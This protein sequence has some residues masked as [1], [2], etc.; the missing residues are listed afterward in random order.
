[1]APSK[2]I[3]TGGSG[4][5]GGSVI[6]GLINPQSGTPIPAGD[7]IAV[8]R[9]EEHAAKM[10]KLGVQAPI[11]ALD[12][13]PAIEKLVLDN[14]V[15]I[16]VHCANAQEISLAQTLLEALAK[17]KEK[18]G[19]EVHYVHTSGTSAYTDRTGWI[20][21]PVR[22]TDPLY[23]LEKQIVGQ[24]P[25]RDANVSVYE[26]AKQLGV[27][28]N[29]VVP[30]F[31]YGEGLGQIGRQTIVMPLLLRSFTKHRA[32]KVASDSTDLPG[33]H[34]NDLVDFYARLIQGI[35]A[36][37][38]LTGYWTPEAHTIVLPDLT[39]GFAK[40]LHARGLVDSPEVSTWES[41]EAAGEA[42]GLPVGFVSI[43]FRSKATII[44]IRAQKE[45]GWEPKWNSSEKH[46]ASLDEEVD[47]FLRNSS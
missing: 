1:M 44:S 37:K 47:S 21:G 46:L 11:V 24:Y 7:I 36:G 20:H 17:Q 27:T 40:V 45:L 6:A 19:Q 13:G 22:D 42:F 41:D 28:L 35:R 23:E 29:T 33:I 5:I 12:D 30:P 8:V 2:I 10:S 26:L 31:I 39:A 15:G 32:V 18:T 25:L 14:D 43:V 4:Y 34:I 3:V 16:I 38:A 9:K